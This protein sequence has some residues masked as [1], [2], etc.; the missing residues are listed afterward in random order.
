MKIQIRTLCFILNKYRAFLVVVLHLYLETK[1][2]KGF[3]LDSL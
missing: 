1:E 2:K 3:I